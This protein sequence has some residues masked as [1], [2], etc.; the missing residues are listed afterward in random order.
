LTFGESSLNLGDVPETEPDVLKTPAAAALLG[1]SEDTLVKAANEGRIP[2]WKTPGQHRR[3]SR[4]A[5]LAWRDAQQADQA[6][7]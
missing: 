3:F 1:M 4:A 6:V 7:G 2:C 5:L